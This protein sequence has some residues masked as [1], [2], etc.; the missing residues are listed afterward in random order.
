V[1]GAAFL[2]L[3]NTILKLPWM[4]LL[5]APGSLLCSVG[6][7]HTWQ[8]P[9]QRRD[10]PSTPRRQGFVCPSLTLQPALPLCVTEELSAAQNPPAQSD[11]PFPQL[12]R[13]V[14]VLL[15]GSTTGMAGERG[16]AW[17][18]GVKPPAWHG[19]AWPCESCCRLRSIPQ[20]RNP[21]SSSF[22]S[23]SSL[24]SFQTLPLFLSYWEILQVN[25]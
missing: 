17:E 13:G 20:G 5:P 3:A 19:T 22:S 15:A 9:V 7:N 11:V 8:R 10:L 24:A 6:T 25:C 14:A 23:S 2:Q 18:R 16:P 1:E 12:S 21:S 4:P